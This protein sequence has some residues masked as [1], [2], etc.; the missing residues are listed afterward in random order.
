M[1][2]AFKDKR[3]GAV[4]KGEGLFSL[5]KLAAAG[6]CFCSYTADDNQQVDRQYLSISVR[7]YVLRL[8]VHTCQYRQTM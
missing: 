4:F 6:D 3:D 8:S 5:A 2:N 7:R 1:K